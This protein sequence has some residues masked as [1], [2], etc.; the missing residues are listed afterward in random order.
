MISA[1]KRLNHFIITLTLKGR[2]ILMTN[3]K[4]AAELVKGL[5][6]LNIKGYASQPASV[7]FLRKGIEHEIHFRFLGGYRRHFSNRIFVTYLLPAV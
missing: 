6:Y 5:V 4:Q 3:K 2:E 7:L 1:V